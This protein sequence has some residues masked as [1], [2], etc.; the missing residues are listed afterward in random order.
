M[1]IRWHR[2]KTRCFEAATAESCRAKPPVLSKVQEGMTTTQPAKATTIARHNCRN[3]RRP[4]RQRLKTTTTTKESVIVPCREWPRSRASYVCEASCEQGGYAKE[5]ELREHLVPGG[6][7]AGIPL[8]EAA[9]KEH[10][11]RVRRRR[12]TPSKV[13]ARVAHRSHDKQNTQDKRTD[14]ADRRQNRTRTNKQTHHTTNQPTQKHARD[15]DRGATQATQKSRSSAKQSEGTQKPS[16][17]T[18]KKDEANSKIRARTSSA[19]INR[20]DNEPA[21]K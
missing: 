7:H 13:L 6:T 16:P 17:K 10:Y 5:R 12:G 1:H 4:R 15:G 21:L 18:S 3:R 20:N 2:R 14:K 19:S 9:L 8:Q 11:P